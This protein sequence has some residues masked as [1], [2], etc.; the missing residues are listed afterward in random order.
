MIL[1]NV[2]IALSDTRKHAGVINRILQ[3]GLHVHN[4]LKKKYQ[5]FKC[6][7]HPIY[8]TYRTVLEKYSQEYEENSSY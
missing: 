3:K 7:N 2:S 6:M 5:E 1:H 8:M 4:K